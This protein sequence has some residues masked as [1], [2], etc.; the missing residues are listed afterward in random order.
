IDSDLQSLSALHGERGR[1]PVEQKRSVDL[2]RERT[3]RL[4]LFERDLG[5]AR[6]SVLAVNLKREI[7]A[8]ACRCLRLDGVGLVD[9]YSA[10]GQLQRIEHARSGIVRSD[11]EALGL[12]VYAAILMRPVERAIRAKLRDEEI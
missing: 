8:G 12:A 4:A 9:L 3:Q 7:I 2:E 5:G 10:A 1:F 6:A 11:G